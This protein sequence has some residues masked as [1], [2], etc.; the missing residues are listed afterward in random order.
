MALITR[1]S[2]LFTADVHAMLDRIEEPEVVLRQ[3]IREMT[4]EL[5]RGEQRL[6]R[7]DDEQRQLSRLVAEATAGMSSIDAE[8]DLC[9]AEGEEALART[10]VRRKLIAEQR[11]K[12]AARR[13]EEL[14]GERDVLAERLVE[15]RQALADTRQKAE[16]LGDRSSQSGTFEPEG[17]MPATDAAIGSDAVEV[18]FLKEKQRR[19]S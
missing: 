2:R 18:A 15:W 16:V 8:L 7:I 14:T 6:R 5:A 4:E 13:Q 12:R 17:A 3:A 10:L 19:R 1:I 9:F 11:L